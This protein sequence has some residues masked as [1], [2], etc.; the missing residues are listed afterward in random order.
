MLDQSLLTLQEKGDETIEA[1]VGGTRDRQWQ[2]L[3]TRKGKKRD[4]SLEPLEGMQPNLHFD[5]RPMKLTAELWPPELS[6]N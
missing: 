2:P 4:S 1:D 6:S 3:K 5:F